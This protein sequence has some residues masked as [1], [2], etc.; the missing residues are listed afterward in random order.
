M[1][2]QFGYSL[3][4]SANFLIHKAYMEMFY[5]SEFIN[6]SMVEYINQ[7]MNCEDLG[8]CTMVA[9]FLAKASYPQTSCVGLKPL[10]Y[11]YNMEGENRM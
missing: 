6:S 4:I 2:E 5:I 1:D 7:N 10:H 9:D 8:M 11:P 3:L